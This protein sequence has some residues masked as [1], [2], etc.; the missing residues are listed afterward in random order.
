M[1]V[2]VG[3]YGKHT[4]T[5]AQARTHTHRE[6]SRKASGSVGVDGDVG[7]GKRRLF[8]HFF[9]TLRFATYVL[10][11]HTHLLSSAVQ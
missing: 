3:Y 10:H 7:F 8:A 11:T 1:L 6:T 9:R 2:I 5:R 4:H